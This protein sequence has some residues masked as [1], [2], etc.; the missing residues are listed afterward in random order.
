MYISIHTTTNSKSRASKIARLL[1]EKE[2]CACAQISK[3]QSLYIWREKICE[4]KEFLLQIKSRADYFEEIAKIIKQ[5]HN[6]QIPQILSLPVDS[7]ESA[8]EDWLKGALAN[9]FAP[10]TQKK[11]SP[12]NTQQRTQ[13]KKPKTQSKAQKKG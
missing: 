1:L 3:I 4:H 5:N 7:I 9:K 12:K 2:L 11:S 13:S 10:R 8:Y 6:Y